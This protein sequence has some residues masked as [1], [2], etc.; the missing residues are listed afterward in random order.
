MTTAPCARNS[1][2]RLWCTAVITVLLGVGLN[3]GSGQ[4]RLIVEEQAPPQTHQSAAV[5]LE[6]ATYWETED[7]TE[8]A[9]LVSADGVHI[10]MGI[11]ADREVTYSPRQAFYFFRNLFQTNETESFSYLRRQEDD[12]GGQVRGM[13]R[14]RFRRHGAEQIEEVRLVLSLGQRAE[15][16]KLTEIRAIR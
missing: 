10:V 11:V 16:W 5:F 14:W 7:H 3:V 1:A 15:G 9:E 6:L 2:P 8:L 13:V 12:S 4:G